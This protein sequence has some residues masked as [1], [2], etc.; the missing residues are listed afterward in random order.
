[1]QRESRLEFD[2]AMR[3]DFSTGVKRYRERPTR[4]TYRDR[5][6][7]VRIY[8]LDF[9]LTMTDGTIVHVEIKPAAKLRSA[10]NTRQTLQF[11]TPA[12]GSPS[13]VC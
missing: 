7:K 9:E 12:P 2:A 13:A 6:G 5:D 3:F 10:A 1:M 11:P 4:V 8:Y